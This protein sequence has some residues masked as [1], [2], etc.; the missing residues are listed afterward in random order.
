MQ[1]QLNNAANSELLTAS[2]GSVSVSQ[3]RQTWQGADGANWSELKTVGDWGGIVV[4]GSVVKLHDPGNY[5][6]LFHD[7][8]RYLHAK[9]EPKKPVVFTLLKTFSRD[10]GLTWSEPEAIFESSDVHL[11]EPGA[12]R[13]PDVKSPASSPGTTAANRFGKLGVH[14]RAELVAR[15]YTLGLVEPQADSE[16]VA[17]AVTA[18]SRRR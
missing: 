3:L 6:A 11:C 4:M 1:S 7:D 18:R 10:G 17:L 14:S 15:T 8:G 5:L 9:A 12:I 16:A 2:V 13:S